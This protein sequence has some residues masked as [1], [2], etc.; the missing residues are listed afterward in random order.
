MGPIIQVYD[1]IVPIRPNLDIVLQSKPL[2]PP[3]ITGL[4]A[5][6]RAGLWTKIGN[7]KIESINYPG[8]VST[9][10]D[11]KTG[12][13]SIWFY[14]DGKK[15]VRIGP[16]LPNQYKDKEYLIV[17]DPTDVAHR[18]QTGEYLFPYKELILYNEFT[19][20]TK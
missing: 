3:I 16:Q 9:L 6:I 19:P 7:K 12:K 13:A 10:Y 1:C 8:F 18:I 2:F 14:W 4:S 11:Q 17:W 20:R 5:A 15:S